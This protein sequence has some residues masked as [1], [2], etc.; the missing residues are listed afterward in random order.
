MKR[1]PFVAG[2]FYPENKKVLEKLVKT[3]LKTQKRKIKEKVKALIVPHAAY[4]YSG[5]VAAMGYKQIEN[6]NYEKVIIMAT[7]HSYTFLE[8]ISVGLYDCYETPLG[9]VDVHEDAKK[10]RF[11]F[12]EDVHTTH[13][14]EVQLPFLQVLLSNF[15]I[16][17]LIFGRVDWNYLKGVVNRLVEI[18]DEE[19]LLIA[20]SDLSHYYDYDTAKRLDQETIK[21]I[22]EL[23]LNDLATKEACSL[24]ALIVLLMIAERLKWKPT[25]LGYMN[26]GDVSD[27][28]YS[29]VGYTSIVFY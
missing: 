3:L 29:V 16:I 7:N 26:S 18:I 28:K 21:S 1:K 9:C 24:E 22:V 13:V 27:N 15:K 5:Q 10:L 17:P 20:S 12:V 8:G 11:N 23:N 19:T 4:E 6:Q 25:F 14:I 2:Y